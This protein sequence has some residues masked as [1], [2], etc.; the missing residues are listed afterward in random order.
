MKKPINV[1]KHVI[2]SDVDVA[3]SVDIR[4]IDAQ[5]FACVFAAK[6]ALEKGVLGAFSDFEKAHICNLVEC[7]AHS[8]RSIRK[9]L[10]GEQSA[11]AVD[12]LAVARL[13]IESV[14]TVCYLLQAP[15]NVRLFLKNAWK[16]KYI[17]FLLDREEL[18]KLRRFDDFF[19]KSGIDLMDKLQGVSF[20]T[21]TERRTIE[22]EQLGFPFGPRPESVH[23]KR[24]PTPGSTI[25]SI[26]NQN[27]RQ[28]LERMYAEYEFLCSFAHGDAESVLFRSIA[29]PRSPF[30]HLFTTGEIEKFYQE[31]VL[32]PPVIY[33]ALGT[34]LVATEIAALFPT[35]VDLHATVTKAWTLLTSGSLQCVPAWEIRAK[36]ILGVIGP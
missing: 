18:V 2:A 36:R 28:M 14:Y 30:R 21:D 4:S 12:A 34:I 8:H 22:Y 19:M 29:N 24:F 6:D 27:Q 11:S 5:V 3:Q 35:N 33:S 17:H 7:F 31:R 13:Q 1:I 9:L 26:A 32:E 25:A 15:E 10:Q 16:R 20:V 23:I